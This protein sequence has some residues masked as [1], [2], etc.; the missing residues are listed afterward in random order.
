[1]RECDGLDGEC[2]GGREPR[3]MWIGGVRVDRVWSIVG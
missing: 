3:T 1:V 2:G